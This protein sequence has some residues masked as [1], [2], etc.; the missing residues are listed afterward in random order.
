MRAGVWWENLKEISIFEDLDMNGRFN[1]KMGVKETESECRLVSSG[2]E[3]RSNS[4]WCERGIYSLV[5]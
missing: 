2:S 4:C 5:Q 1:I 3:Q